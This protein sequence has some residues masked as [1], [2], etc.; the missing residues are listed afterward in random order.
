MLDERIAAVLLIG[1]AGD[2]ID[3]A[4][5]GEVSL[6]RCE[7]ME[8]AVARALD[9]ATA[10]DTLL[11]SP[12][13]TSFDQYPNF[14]ERGKHFKDLVAARSAAGGPPEHMMET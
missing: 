9:E 14:E 6:Q 2:A 4:L 5:G 8:R 10:G 12:A 7:T 3:D 13:C 1:E 11:L